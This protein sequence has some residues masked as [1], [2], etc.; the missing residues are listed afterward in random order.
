MGTAGTHKSKAILHPQRL[1]I[2]RTLAAGALTT[3]A[4]ATA[5]PDIPQA[6]LYRHLSTLLDAGVIEVVAERPV[7]GV[8]ERRYGLVTGAAMLSGADLADATREDHFRFF[9]MF[10]TD[11]IG[12]FSRYLER[13]LIDL[14]A[15]G[16]GYRE[17]VLHLTDNEF[18]AFITSLRTL[19]VPLAQNEAGGGRTPRLLA[20]VLFPLEPTQE[21][22]L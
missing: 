7:R 10:A 14:E 18:A 9:S 19:L 4:L 15:D 1:R 2:I 12:Q 5:V 17:A 13:D 21:K 11:L 3:K 6:S 8:V 22:D 20:T 16:V